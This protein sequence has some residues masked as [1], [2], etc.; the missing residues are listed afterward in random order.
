MSLLELML[1]L[2]MLVVIG[3]WRC[4]RFGPFAN[5]RLRKAGEMVRVE[6]AKARNQAMKTGQIQ[7]FQYE[8]ERTVTRWNRT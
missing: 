3:A 8:A 7:V 1:V 5:Q 4:R 6:W 2:A